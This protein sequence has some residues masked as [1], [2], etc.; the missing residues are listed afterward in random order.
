MSSFKKIFWLDLEMTGLVPETDCIIE[1]AA[2]VTDDKLNELDSYTSVVKQDKSV[3]QKMD[4]WN[5][6]C[7]RKSGLYELIPKGKQLAVVENDLLYIIEKH[8]KKE[9][10]VILA[11]NCIYQDRNF[12]RKHMPNLEKRLYY[13]MLDI[14]AWKIL[15]EHKGWVFKKSNNHR[16]LKDTKESIEEFRYYISNMTFKDKQASPSES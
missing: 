9:E 12:I 2:I 5:Q 14:T 3:L 13:R 10:E 4:S 15:F 7:H 1:A 6:K 16:A 8:F 11:G